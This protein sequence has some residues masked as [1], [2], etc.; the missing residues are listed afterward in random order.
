MNPEPEPSAAARLPRERVGILGALEQALQLAQLQPA[1]RDALG[2]LLP[3]CRQGTSAGGLGRWPLRR[4]RPLL[5]LLPLR[6]RWKFSG[7]IAVRL[8]ADAIA[9]A[10]AIAIADAISITIA[11]AIATATATAIATADPVAVTIAIAT[12]IANADAIAIANAITIGDTITVTVAV[13]F[14]LDFSGCWALLRCELRPRF[15]FRCR[16]CV[17]VV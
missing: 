7:S 17:S 5:P 1:K 13:C 15:R 6:R 9:I 14:F 16:P 3:L 10:I 4:R 11:T 12:A 8:L 2:R